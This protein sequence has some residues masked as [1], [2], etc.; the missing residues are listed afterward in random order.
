MQKSGIAARR[1]TRC[2]LALSLALATAAASAQG[3][4]SAGPAAEGAMALDGAAGPLRQPY[5]PIPVL[6]PDLPASG[7]ILYWKP[8]ERL[9]LYAQASRPAAGPTQSAP[10]G[11]TLAPGRAEELA[12][13]EFGPVGALPIANER[14]QV[15]LVFSQP[16]APV[17]KLGAPLLAVPGV[18]ID[19]P[20]KGVYRWNSTKS[21]TIDPEEPLRPLAEYRVTV[22]RG[23]ASLYGK[24]L[25]SPFSFTFHAGE[26]AMTAL[27]SEAAPEREAYELSPAESGSLLLFFNRE[28]N[29]ASV[30]RSLEARVKD[31]PALRFELEGWD[32]AAKRP[33][34]APSAALR[35]R[36]LDVPP[37]D[38][39]VEIVLKAGARAYPGAVPTEVDA[40]LAFHTLFPFKLGELPRETQ[41]GLHRYRADDANPIWLEFS[42]PVDPAGLE[43]FIT[44][45]NA[46]APAA[47]SQGEL[48]SEKKARRVQ[49]GADPSVPEIRVEARNVEVFGRRVRVNGLK[50][51]LDAEYLVSVA[52]GPRDVHGRTLATGGSFRFRLGNPLSYAYFPHRGRGMME[53]QF[54]AKTI[55]EVQELEYL[56]LGAAKVDRIADA[57]RKAPLEAVDLRGLPPQTKHYEVLDLAPW[58]NREG[59]G[60][61][62][63]D[64]EARDKARRQET[65]K[66]WLFLQVTDLA[67]TARVGHDRIVCLVTSLETGKPVSGA[68]VR[69]LDYD[70]ERL[71]GRSDAAGLAVFELKPGFYRQAFYTTRPGRSYPTDNLAI[72]VSKGGDRMYWEPSGHDAWRFDVA[73]RSDPEDVEATRELA[74][75][76]S[77]RMIYRPGETMKFR[78]I[79]RDLRLGE[80]SAAAGRSYEISLVAENGDSPIAS[81]SG[82]TTDA[83]SFWGAFEL[84][85]DLEPGSYRLVHRREASRR[86]TTEWII[87]SN[88]RRLQFQASFDTSLLPVLADEDV[89]AALAAEYLAGGAMQGASYSGFWTKEPYAFRPAEPRY[90]DFRFYQGDE[91]GERVNLSSFSGQLDGEGRAT[92][93]QKAAPEGVQGKVYR[94]VARADVTD[95]LTG[96]TVSAT[97]SVIV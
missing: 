25:K 44:V 21:L 28:A 23:A 68:A 32:A 26:F 48:Q 37:E 43:A 80:Y 18:S 70:T 87:V 62:R 66:P 42:H 5:G 65:Y 56:K 31:G 90:A 93:R 58:L 75:L 13:L 35:L 67:V 59:K 49:S 7:K 74:F 19:P 8:Q 6:H 20:L 55:A 71:S 16:M 91:W 81:V 86:R 36:L 54:P 73:G 22:E 72:E 57:D 89:R 82:V 64:W 30:K 60:W 78:G 94:Y 40:Q 50:F 1:A 39:A 77:D 27:R 96:Q 51:D 2:L 34:A 47:L 88:F 33:G 29:A 52:P 46:N 41:R 69:L 83:G 9:D 38:S 97:K 4:P 61:V 17:A 85:A 84:P 63:V 10:G 53:A 92:I 11:A 14:P 79:D 15:Y 24:S 3:A 45:K 76:F 95:N 12:V